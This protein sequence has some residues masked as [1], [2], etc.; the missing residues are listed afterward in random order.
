MVRSER[1][2]G[3]NNFKPF[4]PLSD[5]G[6]VPYV[7]LRLPTGAGKTLL[8]G[9][10]IPIAGDSFVEKEYPLTFW[11]VPTNPIKSQTLETLQNPNHANYK[12]LDNAFNGKFR[13]FDIADFRQIRPQD[14]ADSTCIVIST[15]A[16]L[17]VKDH[18]TLQ[19]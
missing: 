11:L 14:I 2:G 1:Y 7:C 8:S 10:T 19:F 15:F 5:L 17:R 3:G 18:S 6:D 16:S 4:Q 9:H 13:V 12:V